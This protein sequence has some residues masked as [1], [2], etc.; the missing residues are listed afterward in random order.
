VPVKVASGWGVRREKPEY[1]ALQKIARE[2]NLSLA[3][4]RKTCQQCFTPR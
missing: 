4:L 1:E 3:E 2:Q